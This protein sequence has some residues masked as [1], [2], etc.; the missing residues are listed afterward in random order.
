MLCT[1]YDVCVCVCVC[2]WCIFLPSTTM[3][4]I[5][6]EWVKLLALFFGLLSCK[7]TRLLNTLHTYIHTHRHKTQT[8]YNV[9]I[10]LIYTSFV[11]TKAY[12]SPTKAA[13]F[14]SWRHQSMFEDTNHTVYSLHRHILS[15]L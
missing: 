1:L 13:Q 11:S 9:C 4:G 3:D 10:V 6:D 15:L 14:K 2:A 5:L 8:Q 12:K 7:H